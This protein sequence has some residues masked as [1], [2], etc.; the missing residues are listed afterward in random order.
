MAPALAAL[1]DRAY[2]HYVPVI[3]RRPVPMDDD[4]AA[5][6]AAGEAFWL[7]DAEDALLALIVL[8]DAADHL[9]VDNV[10]VEPAQHHQ[11]LGRALLAFAEAEARRRGYTELRLLTNERMTRNIGVYERCGYAEY[12]RREENGMRRVYM[13]KPLQG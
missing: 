1:V 3:G 13:R 10:A 7:A 8:E 2:A 6:C 4:Y 11:G 9:W 12:D 5:R